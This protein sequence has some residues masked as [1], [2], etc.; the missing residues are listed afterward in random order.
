MYYLI[1]SS[2]P[3][4]KYELYAKL[5]VPNATVNVIMKHYLKLLYIL[6]INFL[7]RF[8][9]YILN[10]GSLIVSPSRHGHV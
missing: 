8:L 7:V 10:E 5:K 4:N 6:F 9:I 3:L 1:A 2:G